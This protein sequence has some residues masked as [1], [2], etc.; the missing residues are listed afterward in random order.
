MQ[1]FVWPAPQ[2]RPSKNDAFLC[3]GSTENGKNG[4]LA[5]DSFAKNAGLLHFEVGF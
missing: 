1:V 3:R 2:Q 4:L 5:I